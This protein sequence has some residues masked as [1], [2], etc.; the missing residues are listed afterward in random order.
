[1]YQKHQLNYKHQN[2]PVQCVTDVEASTKQQTEKL[3]EA[4]CHFCKKKA[5][6]ARRNTTFSRLAE[7]L[8]NSQTHT[9]TH[10]LLDGTT[11]NM[12]SDEYSL[13]YT[14]GQDTAP[15]ILV[16]LQVN[17]KDLPWSWI[18]EQN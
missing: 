18:L 15:P 16:T 4:E 10:Q 7:R 13:Y 6:F 2:R 3:Q 17:G 12:E 8:Q 5:T 14:Q 9:R 1:M 11:D